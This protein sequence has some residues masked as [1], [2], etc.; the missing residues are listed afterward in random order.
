MLE[1]KEVSR[2]SGRDPILNRTS[3]QIQPDVPAAILG[4]PALQREA[5]LRLLAGTDLPQAGSVRLDG[6]D[7]ARVRREKGRIVCIGPAGAKPSGR[8]VGRLIGRDAA[9]RSG[10]GS[11]LDAKVSD[12]DLDQRLRLAIAVAR[13]G[14]PAMVL[15]N[16]PGAELEFEV[17]KRFLADLEPMLTGTGGVVV[18]VAGAADEAWGLGGL[19]VVLDQG[20]V[21]QSGPVA[22]VFAHPATLAAAL[23]TSYPALN[24]IAM[25]ARD[26]AG[27]LQDGSTFQPP[28]GMV[29]PEQGPC[30][31]AFRPEDAC[32]ERQGAGCQR[33]IVRAAGEERVAGR[34]FMRVTFAGASWLAPSPVAPP[35]AGAVLNAFV[36][37]T[38]LMVFQSEGRAV[39][40]VLAPIAFST[41]AG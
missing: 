38:R 10:L 26:G 24:R 19:V 5:L 30:T 20:R 27:L 14:R 1:L 11:K 15:L 34:R 40:Q 32:L 37:R 12:L 13:E 9:D 35:P 2:S 29:L 8:R 3:L 21:V 6:K 36:D 31:L 33:F 7:L 41:D 16:A 22:D 25:T 28:V 23:A 4:L 18:L 39:P 17:R